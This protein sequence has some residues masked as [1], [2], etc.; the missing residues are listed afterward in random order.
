VVTVFL[1]FEDVS[2]IEIQRHLHSVYGEH[3][4]DVNTVRCWVRIMASVFWDKEGTLIL[5][6]VYLENG[7]KSAQRGAR[8]L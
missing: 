4:V 2:P 7:K 3:T 5:L 1:T 8:E 6:V